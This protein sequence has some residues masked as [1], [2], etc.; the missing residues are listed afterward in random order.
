MGAFVLCYIVIV[1]FIQMSTNRITPLMKLYLENQYKLTSKLL[2]KQRVPKDC[3]RPLSI[4]AII[5]LTTQE[6]KEE[7]DEEQFSAWLERR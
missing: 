5:A 4:H 7:E 1:I 3:S 6:E 2:D